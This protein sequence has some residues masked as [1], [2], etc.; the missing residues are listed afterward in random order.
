METSVQSQTYVF[1]ATLIAGIA[2][3]L[4][5]DFYRLFRYYSRPKKIK[6]FIQDL[7]FWLL[8]SF[9]IVIFVNKV[10][11][12]ELRGFL[13]IGFIIGI[14]LYSRLLSKKIIRFI[15]YTIDFII[16][17]IKHMFKIIFRPFSLCKG[18]IRKAKISFRKYL[19]LPKLF[20]SNTVKSI[21]T[22]MKKK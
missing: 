19:N 2:I 1:L 6:T 20:F 5:Y 10:N 11:E 18:R 13:F 3:G 9:M 7:F 12:G 22:I 8:L 4:I 14:I 15:S 16:D 21:N 17:K